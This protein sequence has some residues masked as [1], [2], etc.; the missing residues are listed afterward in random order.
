[1]R[2]GL[3]IILLIYTYIHTNILFTLLLAPKTPTLKKN[4]QLRA[5]EDSPGPP[6][7]VRKS[8][9]LANKYKNG[10]SSSMLI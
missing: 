5:L 2:E 1:M 6:E 10:S 8:P 4:K 9:R 3:L 7:F